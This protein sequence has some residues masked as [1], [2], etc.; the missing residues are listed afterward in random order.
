MKRSVY[1]LVLMDDVI[2]AVDEQ[3]YR[4]GTSRS[5]LINQILAERLSCV[6]PEMRMREIFDSMTELIGGAFRIQQQ[7]SASLMTLRTALDYKYRP[8]INFKVELERAPVDC[9]GTLRVQIRTQSAALINLF[10]SFF[11]GWVSLEK[12]CLTERGYNNY[13]YE[14]GECGNFHR[15]SYSQ[16]SA[17][18]SWQRNRQNFRNG[19]NHY[20]QTFCRYEKFSENVR[21]QHGGRG[22]SV[23]CGG[24]RDNRG[25][26]L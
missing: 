8:T 24:L 6:T 19:N 13:M 7:R 4:L 12:E 20:N 21:D 14:L 1:S 2:K 25:A 23:G 15:Q 22:F 18:N 10:D 26:V 16:H 9:L 5:N 17:G 11:S 3:A